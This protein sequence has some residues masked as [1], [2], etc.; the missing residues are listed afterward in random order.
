LNITNYDGVSG[1]TTFGGHGEAEKMVP[2]LKIQ[3][4]QL[5][6]VQ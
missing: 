2:V 4:G 6:Q 1:V 5:Q 3:N